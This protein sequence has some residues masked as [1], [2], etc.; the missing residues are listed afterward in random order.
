MLYNVKLKLPFELPFRSIEWFD[1]LSLSGDNDYGYDLPREF[2]SDDAIRFFSKYD[3]EVTGCEY[4]DFSANYLQRIHV[5]G[6]KICDKVKFNWAFGGFHVFNFYE[7]NEKKW[8]HTMD[9]LEEQ[10]SHFFTPEEVELLESNP[11]SFPSMCRIGKPHNIVN[12]NERLRLFNINVWKNGT[13]RSHR[14]YGGLDIDDAL[15]IFNEYVSR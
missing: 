6:S 11:I 7:I 13:K 3:M 8:K 9:N 12:G 4:F 10:N 15:V 5:D 1:S 14:D 2:V